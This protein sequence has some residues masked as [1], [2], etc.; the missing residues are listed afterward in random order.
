M[1]V[2]GRKF[3]ENPAAAQERTW[4]IQKL[5]YK[6]PYGKATFNRK[7]G[8]VGECVGLSR[9]EKFICLLALCFV[10]ATAAAGALR[11]RHGPGELE[12]EAAPLPS[13]SA[14]MES[15]WRDGRLRLNAAAAADLDELPGIGP[16]LAERIVA[17]REARGGFSD[18]SELLDVDGIG[19]ATLEEI[20]PYLIVEDDYA[21]IGSG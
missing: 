9:G 20:L 16:V 2:R 12:R 1:P 19:A 15:P 5:L 7:K 4:A 3:S 10:L 13:V 6:F 18:V 17:L 14:G 8:K 21:D 11:G